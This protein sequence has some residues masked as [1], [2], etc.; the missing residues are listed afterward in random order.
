MRR[1]RKEVMMTDEVLYWHA[2]A[3]RAEGRI[4]KEEMKKDEQIK[5]LRNKLDYMEER[6]RKAE[7]KVEEMGAAIEEINLASGILLRQMALAYGG[8]SKTI[9]IPRG[10]D[11]FG[12]QADVSL[13]EE[14]NVTIIK[15][16]PQ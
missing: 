5:V 4:R 16:T 10:G 6:C 8:D 15:L 2:R 1:E 9:E 12:W 14:R 7:K 11:I 13:D 3:N